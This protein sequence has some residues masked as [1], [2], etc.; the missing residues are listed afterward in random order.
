MTISVV[1]SCK[2]VTTI[3]SPVPFEVL[4]QMGFM[5]ATCPEGCGH[6]MVIEEDTSSLDKLERSTVV[7]KT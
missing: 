1:L 5:A 2:H 7:S 4:D 3:N 6:R